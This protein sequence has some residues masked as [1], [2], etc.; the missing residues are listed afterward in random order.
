LKQASFTQKCN[1]IVKNV[2]ATKFERYAGFVTSDGTRRFGDRSV[3]DDRVNFVLGCLS[4]IGLNQMSTNLHDLV[5]YACKNI[6]RLKVEIDEDEEGDNPIGTA[7][8]SL[9]LKTFFSGSEFDDYYTLLGRVRSKQKDVESLKVV[10]MKRL[11]SWLLSVPDY[12]ESALATSDTVRRKRDYKDILIANTK[13]T[14]ARVIS[15]EEFINDRARWATSGSTD[16]KNVVSQGLQKSKWG[17]ALSMTDKQLQDLYFKSDTD[18]NCAVIEKKEP[19]LPRQVV[20]VPLRVHL[21]MGYLLYYIEPL[22]KTNRYMYFYMNEQNKNKAWLDMAMSV[23]MK[24]DTVKLDGKGWD[25]SILRQYQVELYEVIGELINERYGI[26]V[27]YEIDQIKHF[28]SNAT[29]DISSLLEVGITDSDLAAAGLRRKYKIVNGMESGRRDTAFTNSVENVRRMKTMFEK[30][31]AAG[32]D[33]FAWNTNKYTLDEIVESM[34]KIGFP[35]NQQKS[36]TGIGVDFL[37]MGTDRKNLPSGRMIR[38]LRS[39]MWS[40]DDELSVNRL[41]S[42]MNSRVDIW[43]KTIMRGI[44]NDTDIINIVKCARD[45]LFEVAGRQTSKSTIELALYTPRCEGGLGLLPVPDMPTGAKLI[46]EVNQDKTEYKINYK[47]GPTVSSLPYKAILSHMFSQKIPDTRVSVRE[48]RAKVTTAYFPYVS[49]N[50]KRKPILPRVPDTIPKSRT[51]SM[52]LSTF[53]DYADA[54][55]SLAEHYPNQSEMMKA[56]LLYIKNRTSRAVRETYIKTSGKLSTPLLWSY[57]YGEILGPLF[58]S[59][60]GQTLMATNVAFKLTQ[61]TYDSLC[62]W[63]ELNSFMYVNVPPWYVP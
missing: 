7:N 52:I 10:H 56:D 33:S 13:S 27:A 12:A 26:N 22:L 23:E 54:A 40:T 15:R 48:F 60:Y 9:Y 61:G 14:P 20:L 63:S 53:Q 34:D 35:I 46:T 58:W 62:R 41:G 24:E 18:F 17:V 6:V 29:I 8:I 37:K 11:T 21:L 55:E 38:S 3:P 19:G 50:S 45:D 59:K 28:L 16:H 1:D 4:R 43:A 47:S 44:T 49:F 57:K 31:F 36:S 32:D 25:E 51:D 42:K 30:I 39:V 5:V 2:D